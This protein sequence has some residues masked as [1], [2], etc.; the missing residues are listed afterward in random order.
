M[1]AGQSLELAWYAYDRDFD[2]TRP[3]VAVAERLFAI[4]S[5]FLFSDALIPLLHRQAGFEGTEVEGDPI[6]QICW[7]AIYFV[8]FVLI[9]RSPHRTLRAVLRD[10]WALLI[11]GLAF[12][13]AIWSPAPLVTLRHC[14]GLIGTTLFAAYIASRYD[15]REILDLLFTA[16]SLVGLLSLAFV[17]LLP[18]YGIHHAD[19]HDGLWRGVFTGKNHLGRIMALY[20]V[21]CIACMRDKSH[22]RA[23]YCAG[24]LLAAL[25]AFKAQSM[26]ALGVVVT[27][28]LLILFLMVFRL[29]PLYSVPLFLVTA[30]AALAAGM[31][32]WANAG[33]ILTG[34][35][36]DMTL[37][38]R[39][40]LW[41]AVLQ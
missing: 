38:G 33:L 29:R 40:V 34:V 30:V 23:K 16:L 17:L 18:A 8:T 14:V 9:S 35:G 6:Q 15:A 5:L 11:T 41:A 7:F 32:A 28:P 10:K 37:T 21:V 2:Q 13:S 1:E 36:R 27:T 3:R 19:V 26:T 31:V 12:A 20:G 24:I 39:T 25:L 22:T 4:L